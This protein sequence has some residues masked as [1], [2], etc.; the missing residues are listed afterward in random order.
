MCSLWS[1]YLYRQD[2]MIS[3]IH[4]MEKMELKIRPR[5]VLLSVN[6]KVNSE[7]TIYCFHLCL[8]V[9]WVHCRFTKFI[10]IWKEYNT[11]VDV[12]LGVWVNHKYNYWYYFDICIWHCSFS[13]K[14]YFFNKYIR[15][16]WFYFFIMLMF[17]SK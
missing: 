3:T 11:S 12:L 10:P 4:Y 8:N 6:H 9:T 7:L 5:I 16:I 15:N 14:F 1:V 13:N 2:Q 17:M